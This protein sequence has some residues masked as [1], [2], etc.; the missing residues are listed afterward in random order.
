MKTITATTMI[1]KRAAPTEDPIIMAVSAVA[2]VV[3]VVDDTSVEDSAV[4]DK[5]V[6]DE[7]VVDESVIDVIVVLHVVEDDGNDVDDVEVVSFSTL[8]DSSSA[9]K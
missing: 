7:S 3:V 2:V 8:N 1:T 4:V 9:A 5:S 6:V